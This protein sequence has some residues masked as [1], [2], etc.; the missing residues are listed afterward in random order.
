MFCWVYVAVT[1][2]KE[3]VSY[4]GRFEGN[5]PVRAKE[6]KD[7]TGLFRSVCPLSEK[8]SWR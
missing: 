8:N 7:G 5:F 2:E 3:C 1:D 4:M 6:G